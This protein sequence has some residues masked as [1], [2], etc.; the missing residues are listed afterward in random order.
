MAELEG[1]FSSKMNLELCI[2]V[3]Y[4][5]ELSLE[6]STEF[7]F[8]RQIPIKDLKLRFMIFNHASIF[9][10]PPPYS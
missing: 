7:K 4:L 10:Y 8:L 9:L 5:A 6:K 3:I 2:F 1:N